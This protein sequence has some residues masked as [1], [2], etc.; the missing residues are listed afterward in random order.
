MVNVFDGACPNSLQIAK[1][2]FLLAQWNSEQHNKVLKPFII[3]IHYCIIIN[4]YYNYI[5][6]AK[7][8]YYISNKCLLEECG[9]GESMAV[10]TAATIFFLREKTVNRSVQ[11]HVIALSPL[12]PVSRNRPV[13]AP[14]NVT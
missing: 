10:T 13:T 5:I 1:K 3:I 9:R 4:T 2:L 8:N 11:C 12:C 7:Y 6:N 14:S